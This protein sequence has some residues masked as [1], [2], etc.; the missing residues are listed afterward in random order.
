MYGNSDYDSNLRPAFET[1]HSR[2]WKYLKTVDT[3]PALVFGLCYLDAPQA[4]HRGETS[5]ALP[6]PAER[7]QRFVVQELKR[8]YREYYNTPDIP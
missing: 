6:K 3:K 8:I 1:F 5:V 2:V 7:R 4:L